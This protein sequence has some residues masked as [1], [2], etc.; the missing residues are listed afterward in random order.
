MKCLLCEGW[1]ISRNDLYCNDHKE[2]FGNEL[3]WQAKVTHDLEQ[4]AE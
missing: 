2:Q 1:I 3:P 4:D